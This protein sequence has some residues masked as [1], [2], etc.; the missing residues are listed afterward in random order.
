MCPLQTNNVSQIC[1]LDF[2]ELSQINLT[3]ALLLLIQLCCDYALFGGGDQVA[4][5]PEAAGRREE[6]KRRSLVGP[7][8]PILIRP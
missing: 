4:G 6:N 7:L 8:K 2:W 5:G 1:P 3:Y